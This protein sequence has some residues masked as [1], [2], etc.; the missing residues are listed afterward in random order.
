[1]EIIK[2]YALAITAFLFLAILISPFIKKTAWP[3]HGVL[4]VS[5]EGLHS[6]S[7]TPE[8][9]SAMPRVNIQVE[10]RDGTNTRFEGIP[11]IGI[12]KE[13]GLAIGEDLRGKGLTRFVQVTGEDGY[14][15][16]FSLPELDPGFS[17]GSVIL[18]DVENGKPLSEGDG[19]YRL[20]VPGEKRQARWVKGVVRIQVVDGR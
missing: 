6:L 14:Q 10:R 4:A 12:L 20:V 8:Q 2:K 18:A 9:L 3:D 19:P 13:A 17:E 15:V 5:G 11:L 1:M 7:L 16:V